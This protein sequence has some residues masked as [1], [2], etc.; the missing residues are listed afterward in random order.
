MQRRWWLT[1]AGVLVFNSNTALAKPIKAAVSSIGSY[2]DEIGSAVDDGDPVEAAV[3]G[4]RIHLAMQ[5]AIARARTHGFLTASGHSKKPMPALYGRKIWNASDKRAAK[6]NKWMKKTTR[7]VLTNT[8]DSAHVLSKER[9]LAAVKYEAAR[10]Y[11]RGVR[12]GFSGTGFTKTWITTSADPCDNCQ[13]NE[14][15][16]P[17]D[18]DDVFP[19]GDDYPALHQNCNCMIGVQRGK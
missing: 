15:A 16:G 8:P 7:R 9:A 11:F 12:D 18:V 5:T 14:D 19:S 2:F 3:R 10:G 6:V 1:A 17:I 13:D 4:M